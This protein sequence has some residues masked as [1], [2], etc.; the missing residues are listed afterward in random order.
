MIKR[1]Y[2]L[3]FANLEIVRLII[4]KYEKSI[5]KSLCVNNIINKKQ[6]YLNIVYYTLRFNISSCLE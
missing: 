5:C 3:L 2:F 6:Y 1:D 4:K